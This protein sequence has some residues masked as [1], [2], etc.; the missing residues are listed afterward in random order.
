MKYKDLIYRIRGCVFEVSRV[1]GVGLL[2]SAYEV[3]LMHELL[4]NGIKA[5]RQVC[6]PLKYKDLLVKDAYRVDI[7][8]EDSIILELKSV[9]VVTD[10]HRK[11]LLNYLKLTGAPVGLLINFNEPTVYIRAIANNYD[12]NADLKSLI[13]N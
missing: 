7:L 8:V 1:L 13:V 11:Q 6:V 9:E 12:E 10:V 2:E 5:Q 3:A 4:L